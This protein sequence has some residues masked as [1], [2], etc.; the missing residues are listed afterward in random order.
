[1]NSNATAAPASGLSFY[2]PEVPRAHTV[3]HIPSSH[4]LYIGPQS[5]ERRHDIHARQYGDRNTCSFLFITQ[6]DVVSGSYEDLIVEAISNLR[7]LLEPQPHIFFLAV[8]CID[9]FLGTDDEALICRLSSAY[10]DCQFAME[11]IDPVSLNERMSMGTKLFRTQYSF[12]KPVAPEDHDRG[13]N[14]LGVFVPFHPDCELLSLLDE[15]DAHPLRAITF[16]KT[17]DDYEDMGKS[18]LNMVFRTMNTSAADVMQERLGIPWLLC[19]PSYSA[20]AVAACY[21]QI[22]RALGKP[23]RDFSDD[24]QSCEEDAR[25]T[26]ALLAGIPIALD[27]E[28]TLMV[29]AAAKALIEYGFNVRWIFRSNHQFPLDGEAEAWITQNRPDITV[30][31]TASHEHYLDTVGSQ[32]MLALGVD[33]AR[34]MKAAHWVDIWHDEG[35]FGFHGIHRLFAAMRE[36]IT[37]TSTWDGD[38]AEPADTKEGE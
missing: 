27:C 35:Y 18:C 19:T 22:A 21:N 8:F 20:R 23:E 16:A 5:C 32:N 9:D 4:T 12:I 28:F 14:L 26:V 17:Y 38:A 10:P 15:W 29:F 36:G 6:A 37:R 33:A 3:M 25:Q 1:M 7:E 34:I 13:V 11:H 30:T 31:R 24:I 2:L